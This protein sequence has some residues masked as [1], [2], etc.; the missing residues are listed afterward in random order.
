MSDNEYNGEDDHQYEADPE[1]FVKVCIW[2]GATRSYDG[3]CV[4]VNEN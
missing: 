3:P 1:T 4:T 2:C